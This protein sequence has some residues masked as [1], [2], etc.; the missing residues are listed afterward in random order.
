MDFIKQEDFVKEEEEYE[1]GIPS[2]V[3]P[4]PWNDEDTKSTMIFRDF[5]GLPIEP[6]TSVV[7]AL[8]TLIRFDE[9]I[10]PFERKINHSDDGLRDWRENH[11]KAVDLNI[12][13]L[14]GYPQLRTCHQGISTWNDKAWENRYSYLVE[15]RRKI[16]DKRLTQ[17]GIK[18]PMRE[19]FFRQ[20]PEHPRRAILAHDSSGRLRSIKLR[21]DW[22]QPVNVLLRRLARQ[23]PGR[24]DEIFYKF[25]NPSPG[26]RC[27][28]GIDE[29]RF[30]NPRRT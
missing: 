5:G 22:W 10:V 20:E 13:G 28:D 19:R 4:F 25:W 2:H 30:V 11:K 12:V 27:E 23:F 26:L 18:K 6:A 24:S 15:Q 8:R 3:P 9:L 17:I 16:I 1:P 7:I 14:P 29:L 21:C